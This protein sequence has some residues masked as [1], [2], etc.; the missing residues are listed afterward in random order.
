MTIV[1]T[2]A[3]HRTRLTKNNTLYRTYNPTIRCSHRFIDCSKCASRVFSQHKTKQA[4]K[5]ERAHHCS[6]CK[7]CNAKMDHHCPFVQ[8]CVGIHN[9]R[10]FVQMLVYGFVGGIVSLMQLGRF[11]K[12]KFYD[13]VEDWRD[14]KVYSWVL[15][16]I[17]VAVIQVVYT[18]TSMFMGSKQLSMVSHN[19]NTLENMKV[20]NRDLYNLGILYNLKDFFIDFTHLLLPIKAKI[21]FE[22]YFFHMRGVDAEFETVVFHPDTVDSDPLVADESLSL[23]KLLLRYKDEETQFHKKIERQRVFIFNS[24]KISE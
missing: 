10:Y 5:P 7:L 6:I 13:T 4:L 18:C 2:I 8:N 17:F 21:K 15:F 23:E 24:V 14:Y 20:C 12:F 3:Y 22:G 11:S 19:L 16:I 9:H 1:V